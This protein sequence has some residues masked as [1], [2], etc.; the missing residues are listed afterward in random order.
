M[1]KSKKSKS[2]ARAAPSHVQDREQPCEQQVDSMALQVIR[3]KLE[4]LWATCSPMDS[5]RVRHYLENPTEEERWMLDAWRKCG[6]N[7]RART[8]NIGVSEAARRTITPFGL[9]CLIAY[10]QAWL[11]QAEA[12]AIKAETAAKSR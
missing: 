8:F 11:D 1:N 7:D 5:A 3:S 2:R 6:R 12:L 10:C 9:A 4:G